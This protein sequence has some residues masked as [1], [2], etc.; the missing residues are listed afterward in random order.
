MSSIRKWLV[1][2]VFS[3]V[4]SAN[5]GSTTNVSGNATNGNLND[6]STSSGTGNN[7][8]G[9]GSFFG[10][11]TSSV[12]SMLRDFTG[13]S[14][15]TGYELTGSPLNNV[16]DQSYFSVIY[17]HHQSK[18]KKRQH[19]QLHQQN[20][21]NNKIL[22]NL[23]SVF[24]YANEELNL[25]SSE[26]DTFDGRKDTDRCSTL[27]N[28]LKIAQDRVI[29]TIFTIMDMIGCERASR[30]Y[31]LKFPDELLTGEGIESLNSQIWFGA[32]CLTHGSTITNNQDKSNYLRPIANN[33]TTTLDHIR[34]ELRSCCNYLPKNLRFPKDLIKKL[35]RFDR[36]FTAFE[37]DYVK[38]MLEI[39]S[40][41]EIENLQELTFLFSDT[42]TYA[43]KNNLILKDEVDGCQPSVMIALP[44]L[45]I[46]RGL[47]QGYDSVVC[48]INQEELTSILRPYHSILLD[49]HDILMILDQE[50]ILFIEKLLS[51][52]HDQIELNDNFT[53]QANNPL[54]SVVETTD[55]LSAFNKFFKYVKRLKEID[56]SCGARTENESQHKNQERLTEFQNCINSK[57]FK[58][59]NDDS[60]KIN[61]FVSASVDVINNN[62]NS[63]CFHT[64]IEHFTT[65]KQFYRF[66]SLPNLT[67]FSSDTCDKVEYN[68]FENNKKMDQKLTN[69]SPKRSLESPD[70]ST[71]TSNC[72]NSSTNS[73]SSCPS[74]S[75]TCSSS[76]SMS[77]ELDFLK[78]F[79]DMI[80]RNQESKKTTNNHDIRQPRSTS[81]AHPTTDCESLNTETNRRAK[82]AFTDTNQVSDFVTGTK[83]NQ[84]TNVFTPSTS[85]FSNQSIHF[86][87]G[88]SLTD[89]QLN[90]YIKKILHQIFVM[91]SRIADEFQTNYASDLRNILRTVFLFQEL[92]DERIDKNLMKPIDVHLGQF[93]DENE[94]NGNDGHLQH[95]VE[96][97]IDAHEYLGPKKSNVEATQFIEDL[98]P[99]TSWNDQNL[100]SSQGMNPCSNVQ[101]NQS[102]TESSLSSTDNCDKIDNSYQCDTNDKTSNDLICRTNSLDD[103]VQQI[104]VTSHVA[105]ISS[106]YPSSGKGSVNSLNNNY[107]SQNDSRRKNLRKISNVS[108]QSSHSSN[109]ANSWRSLQ[110]SQ[111]TSSS[112]TT[113]DE[114]QRAELP[115]IM[116]STSNSNSTPALQT[117]P[118]LGQVTAGPSA[119]NVLPPPIWIP[120]D[121]VSTCKN[122]SQAF[123]LIRR[124]HH[125][126][127]CGQIFCH[128]CSNNF[129]A[130]KCFGY[131]KPVRVC[132]TC[133]ALTSNST[134]STSTTTV[135]T[136]NH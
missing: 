70:Y 27:V 9:F 25:I 105:V 8:D 12:D 90:I 24:Y 84:E 23:M 34:Y 21:I 31:R 58:I 44:R 17:H 42:L 111:L 102:S 46:V 28:N 61:R 106:S 134:S 117:F 53:N 19:Q 51:T 45:S 10:T 76:S 89:E 123:N 69:R 3:T 119:T 122:C 85:A 98:P 40:S 41:D 112:A 50:E 118:I 97:A 120:D 43:L 108:V 67:Y 55:S 107:Q 68:E 99:S 72:T 33:L 131:V 7:S 100:N 109:S 2:K 15:L 16:E 75:V 136:Q 59:L 64:N 5:D 95:K 104:A 116:F 37:Y 1:S 86:D 121:L 79:K 26:L 132:N 125:C 114:A 80:Q 101:Q 103:V 35:E 126:R 14:P 129:V 6:S 115:P 30:E 48:K 71:T 4:L 66:N 74:L 127:R 73:T 60:L 87:L 91:I 113:I 77:V 38:A 128:Q 54:S 11:F 49:L 92:E 83:T 20:L 36:L 82:T 93:V 110:Q 56:S 32:E 63:K 78:E 13:S 81:S 130:L 52:N 62:I 96:V 94:E 57:N 135:A 29:T 22:I 124:R 18:M 47:L 65:N 39:K 88:S 133:L